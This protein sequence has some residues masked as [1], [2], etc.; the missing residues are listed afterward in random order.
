M[1]MNTQTIE[2]IYSS[3]QNYDS[4]INN[5]VPQFPER[6]YS[7]VSNIVARTSKYRGKKGR[8]GQIVTSDSTGTV[9]V[10]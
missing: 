5:E 10:E 7:I 2:K 3:I 6:T 4:E 8:F 1:F 9:S